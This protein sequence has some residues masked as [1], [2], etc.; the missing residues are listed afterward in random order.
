MLI[1][2]LAAYADTRLA[3]ELEEPAFEFKPV[4]FFLEVSDDGTFLG[5]IERTES[6]QRGSK[7][8]VTVQQLNIAK[9]PVARVSG[10]H[11]LLACDDMKYVLGP[12][13]W[14]KPEEVQNQKERHEAFVALLRT[15]AE[16]TTDGSV[17]SV[18]R[19]YDRPIEVEFCT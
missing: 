11:P 9:S 18:L 5:F 15:A 19:F 2:A 4:R 1:Q 12:G 8:F 6:V 10:L 17:E 7:T 16:A 13:E 14:T 3:G